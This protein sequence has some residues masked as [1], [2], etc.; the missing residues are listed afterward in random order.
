MSKDEALTRYAPLV[1][2]V[3]DR[4]AT[5]LPKTIE[6]DDL[7]NT[8]VIGLFDAMEKFDESRGTKFETY[9]VW[10][11]R[12][13]VLDELRSLDWVSRSVRKKAK[14]VEQVSRRLDQR[15]GRAASD[16]EIA[17][18]LQL[19]TGE[20]NR[21]LE[22]VRGSMLLSLD[23]SFSIDDDHDI[24]GLADMIEDERASDVLNELEL[25]EA[26]DLLL[27]GINRLSDQEKLVIALYYYEE[28][29]LKEIGEA[30]QISESRVSQIHT[31]AIGRLTT[32]MRKA[33]IEGV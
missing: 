32:K 29:T 13:A 27:D 10:R 28:M 24:S 33:L 2:Y 26:R 15:L 1:K 5:G 16:Q 17:D 12:G 22:E 20:F 23:Q 9:A 25:E 11:I 8:A 19:S 4:I 3:V 7:V 30:L 18:E 14:E 6:R 31:K 21:L